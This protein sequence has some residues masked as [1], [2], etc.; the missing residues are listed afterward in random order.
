MLYKSVCLAIAMARY[1]SKDSYMEF[2]LLYSGTISFIIDTVFM[3]S[4]W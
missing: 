3:L 4:N 2:L 1:L